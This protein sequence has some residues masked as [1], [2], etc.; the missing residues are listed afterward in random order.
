MDSV[1]SSTGGGGCGGAKA[2]SRIEVCLLTL[3]C[4]QLRHAVWRH[5]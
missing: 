2:D 1:E 4:W 5:G 3:L